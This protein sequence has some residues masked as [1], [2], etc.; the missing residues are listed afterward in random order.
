MTITSTA[1]TALATLLPFS[2][3]Y[4][5]PEAAMLLRATMPPP[6]GSLKVWLSRRDTFC[7][8]NSRSLYAWV[9]EGLAMESRSQPSSRSLTI[10]FL[11]L[12]RLRMITILRSRGLST[13][14]IRIGE[15][16]ARQLTGSPQPLV[17]EQLWTSSSDLFLRFAEN[18][19]A[20]TRHG[21]PA[22]D[23]LND[24]L[25]PVHHGLSFGPDGRATAWRP[26]KDILIDPEVAF[27]APCIEGTRIQTEALWELHQ[28]G[29]GVESLACM[30]R[31]DI[32]KAAAAIDWEGRLA[33][34]A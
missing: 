28:A 23:F 13:N 1:P 19:V 21:Q 14:A 33:N 10:S 20:A 7:L 32:S 5:V 17:T 24:F 29:D 6:A 3:V 8:P 2:G 27:G 31:I 16:F 25:Q 11:D 34:A 15:S 26:A 4:S 22:M 30:Y 18:L 9:R 12:I